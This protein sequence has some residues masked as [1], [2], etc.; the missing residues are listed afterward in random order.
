MYKL[1][2]S[3]A[4][5]ALSGACN[6]T[7]TGNPVDGKSDLVLDDFTSKSFRI[8][9][10]GGP[11][12]TD[13]FENGEEKL[14]PSA[15]QIEESIA[16]GSAEFIVMMKAEVSQD[17][18]PFIAAGREEDPD[19]ESD[20]A[21]RA[22]VDAIAGSQVCAIED[23]ERIE[24]TYVESFVLINAFLAELTLEQAK[25]LSRRS[26]VHSIELSQSSDPPPQ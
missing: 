13:Q 23:V 21:Y 9:D 10:T 4:F 7:S 25:E 5:V 16:D 14:S 26:D 24:G 22:R 20:S 12:C 3:L 6:G 2:V 11:N 19:L 15:T 18:Y 17:D 1:I 8:D